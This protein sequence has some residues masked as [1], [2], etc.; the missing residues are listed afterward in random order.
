MRL[1]SM[2]SQGYRR[3]LPNQPIDLAQA[4]AVQKK[5]ADQYIYIYIYNKDELRLRLKLENHN[6]SMLR[7][8]LLCNFLAWIECTTLIIISWQKRFEKIQF[9][10]CMAIRCVNMCMRSCRF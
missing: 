10:R 2:L 4:Q 1:P 6:V 7:L 8:A 3:T 5:F 9:L